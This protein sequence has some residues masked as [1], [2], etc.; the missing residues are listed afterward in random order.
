MGLQ[1]QDFLHPP[2]Q[3]DGHFR[4]QLHGFHPS[5]GQE[6]VQVL[7]LR[8]N[9]LPP[10]VQ[11]VGQLFPQEQAMEKD[12]RHGQLH[13]NRESCNLNGKNLD[14]DQVL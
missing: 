13:L 8:Q 1:E 11:E 5:H 14:F 7:L 2:D 4:P 9:L 6:V 12:Q 10:L 3:K